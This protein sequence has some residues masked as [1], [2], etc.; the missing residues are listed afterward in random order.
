MKKLSAGK[1]A[2]CAILIFCI[3]L[4]ISIALIIKKPNTPAVTKPTQASTTLISKPAAPAKS[5]SAPPSKVLFQDLL[6]GPDRIVTNEYMHW[7]PNSSC[8]YASDKWDMT[9]GTL[10]IK[11]Q[12]GY[13]GVPTAENQAVCN[14]ATKTD[15]SVFRLITKTTFSNT[16]TSMDYMLAQH[17]GGNAPDNI[18]DGLHIWIHYQSPDALYVVSVS[19]WDGV[20]VIKKKVPLNVAH[21]TDPSEGGCYYDLSPEIKPARLVQKGLWRHAEITVQD[22][23][24]SQVQISL[25][26]DGQQI[27]SATDNNVHGPTYQSGAA[28]VRGDNTEFYFKNFSVVSL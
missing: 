10:L 25:I 26:I 23:S 6:N 19:R 16:T 21:C 22:D 9:S 18:Y 5:Q 12:A 24:S 13:S 11:N 28:G 1:L 2:F 7:N 3:V 8:P 14:S 27:L 4:A 17:G 20:A 15:S